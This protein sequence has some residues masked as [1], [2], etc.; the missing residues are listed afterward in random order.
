MH[1]LD[2]RLM[3]E[4][5]NIHRVA[6][7]THA[8]QQSLTP[9]EAAARVWKHFPNYGDPSDAS[10]ASPEDRPLP[11]EL[12]DRVNRWLEKERMKNPDEVRRW[13]E[14]SSTLNA[15]IRQEIHTERL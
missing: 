10:I 4:D 2:R 15:L 5:D 6:V 11:Y 8:L 13:R 14:A 7:F 1:D 12:K 3:L 9:Q